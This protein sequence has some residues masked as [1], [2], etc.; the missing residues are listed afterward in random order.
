MKNCSEPFLH[1]FFYL[2]NHS[3]CFVETYSRCIKDHFCLITRKRIV[4]QLLKT[5]WKE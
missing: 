2:P 5:R 4:S 3:H 1:L